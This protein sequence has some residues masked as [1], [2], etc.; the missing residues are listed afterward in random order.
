MSLFAAMQN[1]V[2]AGISATTTIQ[3]VLGL[4]EETAS[5]VMLWV[6]NDPHD[7]D[8]DPVMQIAKE[9]KHLRDFEFALYSRMTRERIAWT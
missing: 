6:A 3:M 8:P 5:E 9:C 2:R 7:H 4:D 1:R